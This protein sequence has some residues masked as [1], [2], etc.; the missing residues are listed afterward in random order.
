MSIQYLSVGYP[1]LLLRYA[2][3][4]DGYSYQFFSLLTIES[5]GYSEEDKVI[6]DPE[7]VR[8]NLAADTRHPTPET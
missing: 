2:D 6:N 8:P 7:S 1:F 4:L 3:Y 5:H